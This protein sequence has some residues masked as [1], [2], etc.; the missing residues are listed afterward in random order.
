MLAE[1]GGRSNFGRGLWGIFPLVVLCACANPP[2][3]STSP[4]GVEAA[5]PPSS[6]L[7]V[8]LD[9]GCT[10]DRDCDGVDIPEDK[11]PDAR[12]FYNGVDD[13]DG[14]PDVG[15]FGIHV[16]EQGEL[17]FD[18]SITFILNTAAIHQESRPVILGLATVI[19]QNLHIGD[20]CID[21]GDSSLEHLVDERQA[22]VKAALVEQGAPE[23]RL[24][25]G[26]ENCGRDGERSPMESAGLDVRLW[27]TPRSDGSRPIYVGPGCA[28]CQY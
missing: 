20:I 21:V 25:L 18:S 5:P 17:V 15:P 1:V 4:P 3:A 22:A 27:V 26:R 14:C 6:S 12:E 2:G 13:G 16:T 9:H 11:C 23:W 10:L 19:R 7:P 28:A 8:A 24:R